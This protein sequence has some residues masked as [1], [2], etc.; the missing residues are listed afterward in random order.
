MYAGAENEAPPDWRTEFT[1]DSGFPY[2]QCV[3]MMCVSKQ[4]RGRRACH[5]CTQGCNGLAS[6]MPSADD[7]P[8]QLSRDLL[9]AASVIL[10]AGQRVQMDPMGPPWLQDPAGHWAHAKAPQKPGMQTGG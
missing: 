8:E 9:P 3:S 10:P 2:V 4:G 7:P 5:W 1:H 6:C